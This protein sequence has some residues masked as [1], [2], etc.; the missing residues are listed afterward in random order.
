MKVI[1][2]FSCGAASAIAAKLAIKKYGADVDVVYMDTGSEHPDNAR[3]F[4]EIQEWLG[5]KITV[6]K[7]EKY[8]DIWDV[9]DKTGFLVS[10]KGARC[11]TEL[12]KKVANDYRKNNLGVIEIFGYTLEEATIK[13]SYKIGDKYVQLTRCKNFERSNP[14]INVEWILPENDLRKSDCLALLDRENIEI[15]AMYKMGYNNNNCI[16]CVK[17]G[18]GYWN[19]IR[20]DFPDIFER[21]SKLDRKL[22]RK[23]NI[24]HLD[25][26]GSRIFLD[27][28][29]PTTGNYPAEIMP[30]CGIVCSLVELDEVGA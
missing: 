4:N 8:F 13:R 20:V 2:W 28:L 22:D 21:M 3:F 6:I 30:S 24:K 29:L 5:V 27:E 12:K 26:S 23:L 10:P 14:E 1:A 9:F 7:S 16:G 19:K 15:P 25:Q 17:G 18:A 11:T